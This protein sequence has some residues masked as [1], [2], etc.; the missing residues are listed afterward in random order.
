M[1]SYQSRR[2]S[3]TPK[4]RSIAQTSRDIVINGDQPSGQSVSVAYSSSQVPKDHRSPSTA[5][6]PTKQSS[7]KRSWERHRAI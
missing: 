7:A 2:S 3:S 6:M 4:S 5:K 1:N